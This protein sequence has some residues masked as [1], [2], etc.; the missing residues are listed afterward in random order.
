MPLLVA[1]AGGGMT[2][3]R[4]H[5][6]KG[7]YLYSHGDFEAA[8]SEYQLA[9]EEEP[10]DHRARFN[11]AASREALADR[12]E[13]GGRA[14]AAEAL[15]QQAEDLYRELL[16]ARPDDLRAAVNLAAREIA[17]GDRGAGEE[18]LRRAVEQH[19]RAALPRTALAAHA[20]RQAGEDPAAL[21]QAVELLEAAL[22]IDPANADANML[23][24]NACGLLARHEPNGGTFLK[25][26]RQAY[27]KVLE[28]DSYDFATLLALARL[29]LAAGDAAA[30]EPWL[31]RALYV[32]PNHL[33]GHLEM[34]RALESLGDLESATLHLWRARELED[35]LA[36]RLAPGEYAERL[37]ELYRR[38]AE[39]EQPP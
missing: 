34:S 21:Q 16:A 14:E 13:R 18:R 17:K 9:L 3:I 4:S 23:L 11:L 12:L 8:I 32:D 33:E 29:E 27:H 37:L 15:R 35:P 5:F 6:N 20:L 2:P 28:G 22:A 7:A 38:L 10:A 1:C 31:R 36:P 26:A 30:A 39:R 19:P 24:G 25:R